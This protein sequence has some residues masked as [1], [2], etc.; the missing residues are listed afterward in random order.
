MEEASADFVEGMGN[1]PEKASIVRGI[2]L[3]FGSLTEFGQNLSANMVYCPIGFFDRPVN[4]RKLLKIYD[5]EAK[6]PENRSK[7][8][9]FLVRFLHQK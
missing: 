6:T 5:S 2:C 1:V 7:F 9:N 8:T 4:S 3:I